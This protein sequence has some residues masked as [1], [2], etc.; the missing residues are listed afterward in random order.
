MFSWKPIY[1]ELAKKI[2]EYRD[3]QN[4]LMDM[5]RELAAK[6]LPAGSTT[7]RDD[8]QKEIPLVEIDPFTFYTCFNRGLTT[9]N[10]KEI[11]SYLKARL[12]LQSEVPTDFE[13]I[14]VVNSQAAWFF[15]YR[16]GRKVD[17][18]PS[19][20]K[21]AEAVVQ[22][23]PED[24]DPSLFERC[25]QIVSVGPAKLTMGMFWLNPEQ[26]IAWDA[27][28]RK[29]SKAKGIDREVNTLASCAIGRRCEQEH[30]CRLRTDFP[31]C[32]GSATG[33]NSPAFTITPEQLEKLWKRFH[34]RV[35]GFTN[36]QSP[37]SL[38]EKASWSTE[39]KGLERFQSEVGNSQ[40]RKWV[41][42]GEG[43]KAQDEISKR[44]QANLVAFQS[45]RASTG[46][47]D[48]QCC[49]VLRAYPDA[50]ANPYAGPSTV[51]Q[52]IEATKAQGL[53]PSWD[54]LSVILWALRPTDY[55]PVKIRH[56]RQLADEIGH[57][58]PGGAP[59]AERFNEVIE[60]GRAFWKALE[61]Q[62]PADW[63]DVQS[64]IWVACP[65]SYTDGNGE[66]KQYWA[67]GFQWGETRKLD[68]FINGN[69]WQIGWDK[70]DPNSAAK[71]TW[72]RFEKVKPGDEFAIKGYGGRGDLQVYY[73]G[74]VIGKSDDGVLQLKQLNRAL[75]HGKGP[76]GLSWFGTLVQIEPESV[77]DVIFHGAKEPEGI[78]EG[79]ET[80]EQAPTALNIILYGPPGTGKTYHSIERAVQIA[81]PDFT[82]DHVTHKKMFDSLV[83]E[84]RI[85]FITFHQSY[86]YED[87]VEGIRPVLDVD[88]DGGPPRYECRPGAFK[89]LA[90]N[91]LFDCIERT[92]AA[93]GIVPFDALW[94][95]L[96]A[97][98]DSDPEAKY[99]GLSA[100]T[101]YRLTLTPK[102]NIEGTNVLSDKKFFCSRKIIEQVFNAKRSQDSVTVSDVMEVVARGCHSQLV[103]AVF[104]ELR[105]VEKLEFRGNVPERRQSTLT[106]EEKA[107]TVQMFLKD[108]DLSGY[109]IKPTSKWKQYVLVVDEINRGNISKILGELITL[110]EPDKRLS[111][112]DGQDG[113]TVTLPYSGEKFAVPGNLSVL[114]R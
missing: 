68:E 95:A 32:L 78:V 28:N 77:I 65:T 7:D 39:R 92:E 11:L 99:P 88:E 82:G 48:T 76:K 57:P 108:R 8:Q 75:Y 110:L 114:Q 80:F 58:L 64:F 70:D 85:E 14:P 6:G 106:E 83:Q 55:F 71:Q 20:W 93:K 44:V 47:N 23:P 79:P 27:N 24:L 91:A 81:V 89:R 97:K 112:G 94:T 10:R 17:D 107:E 51:Q 53:K 4:E 90:L 29:L 2:L 12:D 45:W 56:F 21:L 34:E 16:Y 15:P 84:G 86:S 13:G 41:E 3:R 31:K 87:F 62:K 103:A 49:A 72:T 73:I 113:L 22:S 30:R 36:L 60:F 43:V 33:E 18:I 109:Q 63:I 100:K 54:T 66:E 46:T 105:R 102:G 37:A 59:T 1:I 104:N 19:L 26:Y 69:F 42:A 61:P 50:A 96:L 111:Y 38:F 74:E 9:E 25:L 52:I 101:S 98:I 40:L 67:G 5:L 35:A